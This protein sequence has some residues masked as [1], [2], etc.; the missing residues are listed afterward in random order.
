MACGRIS[1]EARIAGRISSEAGSSAFLYRYRTPFLAPRPHKP[2]TDLKKAFPK[3]DSN[4][5]YEQLR[6]L[7]YIYLEGRYL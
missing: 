3:A 2:S 1:S 5:G 7:L 4:D 6:L